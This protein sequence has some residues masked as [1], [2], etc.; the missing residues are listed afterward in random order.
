MFRHKY[1]AIMPGRAP[2]GCSLEIDL[3]KLFERQN[4]QLKVILDVVQT[5]NKSQSVSLTL[6]RTIHLFEPVA[7]TF[8][9]LR[10]KVEH[11]KNVTPHKLALCELSDKVRMEIREESES[12]RIVSDLDSIEAHVEECETKM[13]VSVCETLQVTGVDLLRIDPEGREIH[14][15]N[16]ARKLIEQGKVAAKYAE[17]DFLPHGLHAS[18]F[19]LHQFFAQCDF[20]FYALYDYSACR[21]R[22]PRPFV[23]ACGYTR[24][25][26]RRTICN[27]PQ[28]QQGVV[29]A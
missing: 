22:Q 6:S 21:T 25:C 5:S 28:P 15:L 9:A 10:T 8:E 4:R 3:A 19:E 16:G 26:G 13:L 14:V 7:T 2:R 18:S 11:L 23:T 17:V 24:A 1:K 20:V 27:H 29:E 12:S